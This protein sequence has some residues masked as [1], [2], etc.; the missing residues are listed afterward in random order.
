M[1]M[2]SD[3]KDFIAKKEESAAELE[4]KARLAFLETL[5]KGATL[6]KHCTSA[7]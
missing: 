5:P 2:S 1:S 6:C 7:M 4:T 3:C